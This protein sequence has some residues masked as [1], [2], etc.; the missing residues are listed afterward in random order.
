[1]GRT[2]KGTSISELRGLLGQAQAAV[3]TDY[4]GLT[5]AEMTEL[6]GLLR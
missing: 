4:R 1:M 3:L 5:V 2:E 6:R